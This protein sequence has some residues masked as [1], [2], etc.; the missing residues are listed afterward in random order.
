MTVGELIQAIKEKSGAQ[1]GP[2]AGDR[3]ICGSE[4]APVTKIATT[5][6]ATSEVIEQAASEGVDFIITHE[7]TYFTGPDR[8]DWIGGNPVYQK[9]QELIDR[10]G[11]SI[12][13]FHDYMHLA[14]EGDLICRGMYQELGWNWDRQGLLGE[15]AGFKRFWADIP[16]VTLREL[17]AS[18][19]E[20][21]GL[22]AIRVIGDPELVCRRA[23]LLPGGACTFL[24]YE[25]LPMEAME[26]EHL[27]VLLCGDILEWTIPSYVRDAEQMGM[28][29]AMI[30]LGHNR[31]EEAGMKHIIPW[32]EPL[33]PGIPI[34]FLESGDPFRFF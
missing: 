22:P 15:G 24:D 25:E 7:P 16:P 3:L 11:I 2:Q 30:I 4:Q 19:K 10:T 31:S 9:K 21:L 13:R 12:W 20:L 23:G 28:P 5:F 27:D 17:A 1:V 26:E 29:R 6:M 32:L 34:V 14:K 8:L 18:L 33:A